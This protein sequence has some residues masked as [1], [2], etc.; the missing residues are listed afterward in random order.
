VTPRARRRRV[1]PSSWLA[2]QPRRPA[3]PPCRRAVPDAQGP[4]A[5]GQA[6]HHSGRGEAGAQCGASAAG[7]MARR[8]AALGGGGRWLVGGRGLV[9]GRGRAL[10][11][12][13]C[14]SSG[15][16]RLRAGSFGQAGQRLPQHLSDNQGQATS[17]PACWDR[18]PLPHLLR[19]RQAAG[20]WHPA[21]QRAP[22]PAQQHSRSSSGNSSSSG[23]SGSSG[24]SCSGSCSGSS[25]SGSCSGSSAH[26][27]PARPAAAGAAA[28][29]GPRARP[30]R[31]R[32]GPRPAAQLQGG[33][34]GRHL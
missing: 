11:A 28:G 26:S 23:S 5:A 7:P 24:S 3:L 21:Q 34:R 18:H 13:L 19:R 9:E 6:V 2:G 8:C 22:A 15:C 16:S 30:W 4:G 25:G 27:S 20:A 17:H 12:W 32:R 1:R 33:R 29:L 10:L 31:P 14:S